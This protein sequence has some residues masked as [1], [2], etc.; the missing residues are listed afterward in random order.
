VWSFFGGVVSRLA[1]VEFARDERSS[2][3]SALR[4]AGGRF[5]SYLCSPLLPI[6]FILVLWLICLVGGVIG[7]I[8]W[9]G[10]ALVGALWLI[11]LVLASFVALLLIGV[12]AGWPLMVATISTEATDAYDGFSRSYSYVYS[13]PWHGLWFVVV[14]MVYGLVVFV[15]VKLLASLVVYLAGWAVSAGMDLENLRPAW[16]PFVSTLADGER[17]VRD[18]PGWMEIGRPL[19]GFWLRVVVLAVVAFGSSYF[20]TAAT[21]IY[22]LL[23]KSEDAAD[24]DEVFLTTEPERDD[25]LP[26]V[27]VAA[28]EQPVIERPPHPPGS[29]A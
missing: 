25:L 7:R 29:D 8:P 17:F 4:F 15:F 21:I 19:A 11:P 2:L 13:R 23:R 1:A 10:E 20:W 16:S 22:V 18:S 9:V 12:A 3:P 27:G 14:A 5:V 28:S 6:A 24:L 26:L